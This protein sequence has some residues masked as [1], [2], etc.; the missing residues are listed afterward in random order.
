MSA[1]SAIRED[2]EA[3]GRERR[4]N[5]RI[6]GGDEEALGALDTDRLLV[7]H[8]TV[9]LVVDDCPSGYVDLLAARFRAAA[10]ST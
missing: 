8:P 6:R 3:L 1:L 10:G 2:A 4:Q 7:R 9:V 5:R